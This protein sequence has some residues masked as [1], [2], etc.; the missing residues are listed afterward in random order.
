MSINNNNIDSY[1]G[2]YYCLFVSG[3]QGNP[4]SC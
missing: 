3:I 4:D 1:V 2:L